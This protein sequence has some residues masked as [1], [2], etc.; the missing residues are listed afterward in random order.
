MYSAEVVYATD[1]SKECQCVSTVRCF[2]SKAE[3]EV[4]VH[5]EDSQYDR[6]VVDHKIVDIH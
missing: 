4:W 5:E 3:A 1:S 2:H 6:T